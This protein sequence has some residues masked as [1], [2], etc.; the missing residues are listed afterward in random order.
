MNGM[1]QKHPKDQSC[2]GQFNLKVLGAHFFELQ[3]V[4]ASLG[5][6]QQQGVATLFAYCI[7]G[8]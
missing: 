8:H 2:T 7:N 6:V 3:I 4:E 5:A 1:L